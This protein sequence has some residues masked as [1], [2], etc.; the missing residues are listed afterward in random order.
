MMAKPAVLILHRLPDGQLSRWTNDFPQFEFVDAR[1]P[2][3]FERRADAVI[4][5]GFNDLHSIEQ[6]PELRWIQLASAG[7]PKGLCPLALK[8]GLTVSNLAGL[9]GPT[10]AEHALAMMLVLNRNLH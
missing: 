8:R 5:Y 6:A 1:S 4:C 9:Y 10:I 7:V 2:E 3:P